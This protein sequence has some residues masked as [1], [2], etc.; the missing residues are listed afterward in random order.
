[1]MMCTC[2]RHSTTRSTI[3][4]CEHFKW[5]AIVAIFAA[6]I[7]AIAAIA[8]IAVITVIAVIV[9]TTAIGDQRGRS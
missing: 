8:V 3:C 1:M 4:A 7:T 2:H 6:A 5:G 9:V